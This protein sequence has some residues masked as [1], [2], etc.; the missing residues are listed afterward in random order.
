MWRENNTR[1][2]AGAGATEV[3]F[4]SRQA[5]DKSARTLVFFLCVRTA[6]DGSPLGI[7]GLGHSVP[8][9]ITPGYARVYYTHSCD[10]HL[11]IARSGWR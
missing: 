10:A 3:H 4:K 1:S 8:D 11:M 6:Y 7:G 2:G 9:F 5:H